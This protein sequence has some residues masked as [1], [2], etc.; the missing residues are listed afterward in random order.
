MPRPDDLS[1]PSRC[2]FAS[3]AA[4]AGGRG[5]Y[6]SWRPWER[7]PRRKRRPSSLKGVWPTWGADEV[8]AITGLGNAARENPGGWK[9]TKIED[10]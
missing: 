6:F 7:G 2:S 1:L 4:P 3:P 10:P 8:A 5:V 9:E